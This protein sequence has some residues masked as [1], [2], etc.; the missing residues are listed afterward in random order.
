MHQRRKLSS[1]NVRRVKFVLF[2]S[3]MTYATYHYFYNYPY[4]ILSTQ[5]FPRTS[6]NASLYDFRITLKDF[7]LSCTNKIFFFG[8]WLRKKSTNERQRQP[9][10]SYAHARPR[11]WTEGSWSKSSFSFYKKNLNYGVQF[12][13]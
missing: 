10:K 2:D 9:Y 6:N 11:G 3:L 5:E 1:S 4:T 13:F 8:S 7:N 12:Y